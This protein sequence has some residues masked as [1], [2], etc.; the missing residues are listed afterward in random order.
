[1]TKRTLKVFLI[2]LM[3]TGCN[4]EINVN[5]QSSKQNTTNSQNESVSSSNSSV[6]VSSNSDVV[7]SS[8]NEVKNELQLLSFKAI[9]ETVAVPM[10]LEGEVNSGQEVLLDEW[11]RNFKVEAIVKNDSRLSFVDMVLYISFLDTYVV[12]TDGNG[13]YSCSTTTILEN[14]IWVTKISFDIN[15]DFSNS[16]FGY[17]EVQEINFLDLNS[18]ISKAN[19]TK[20][21]SKRVNYHRHYG[22]EF[23]RIEPTCSEEGY[24]EF[25]CEYCHETY[26][27]NYVGIDEN[28]HLFIDGICQYCDYKD[29]N[30]YVP[31]AP[32]GYVDVDINYHYVA[33]ELDSSIVTKDTYNCAFTT[34]PTT[35]DYL[36]TNKTYN[37]QYIANFVD[38][39]LEHTPEGD[40]TRGLAYAIFYSEDY[41]K[42]RVELRTG[43]SWVTN[44]MNEYAEVTAYDFKTGLQHLLDAKG[45]A[46]ELAYYIKG[47]KAY[48]DGTDPN[49]ENVGIN[50]ISDYEFEYIF[51]NP[52]PFFHTLLTSSSFKPLNRDFFE[53]MGGMLGERWDPKDCGFGTT[54][55]PQSL[56]YCGPYVLKKHTK[57]ASLSMVKNEKYW[58]KDNV[59]INEI[60]YVYNSGVDAAS[61]VEMF[62][63]GE[64]DSLD[65]NNTNY[66]LVESEFGKEYIHER[67]TGA[68]TYYFNWNLNRQTYSFGDCVSGKTTDAQKENTRK[69]ILNE[70]FRKAIFSAIP[71][72][73]LN[74]LATDSD[75]A[76]NNIRNTYTTPEFVSIGASV[77]NKTGVTHAAG[78]QYY[79]MVNREMK[80]I[81]DKNE[82]D[83]GKYRSTYRKSSESSSEKVEANLSTFKD[84][85]NSYFNKATA[86]DLAKKA[87]T[88]LEKEGVTFP[89]HIDYLCYN[90]DSSLL[91]QAQLLRRIVEKTLNND[92]EFIEINIQGT[93]SMSNYE[94]SH[95]LAP[96]GAD[97]NF[98][99]SSGTG[100]GPEYGDP[101]T[102]LNTL[103]WEGELFNN[104]GFD[105]KPEDKVI[106]EQVLGDYQA[107]Y[108]DAQENVSDVDVRY[109]KFAAAEA[110]LLSSAVIMPN[111][112][113]GGGYAISRIVSETK[114][115]AKYGF[116]I[117]RYKFMV[118]SSTPL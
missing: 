77:E 95:F 20:I 37:Q 114:Q 70:N 89:V 50:I 36:A 30:A 60:N 3:L 49:F 7:N 6:I 99:L 78:S 86:L 118:V 74:A 97:M 56:L 53:E 92:C 14:E 54:T 91:A 42:L 85:E 10:T 12:F 9:D 61:L 65:V 39:L 108:E 1:M 107:L 75:L 48:A 34:D 79:E 5:N 104:L 11:D 16:H 32:E 80:A 112:T 66:D 113:D 4:I 15:V 59:N 71:K 38:G 24:D 40:L 28:N 55:K 43:V 117:Y 52:T 87:K 101:A 96:T 82:D 19:L 68:T 62:K 13:D 17:I 33:D 31:K 27:D 57:G 110:E 102:F 100:W 44:N 109:A 18:S 88:E 72:I 64:L 105:R 29:Y 93:S 46:K 25:T 106:Y 21:D 81:N 47:A 51:E 58:D 116:D 22:E 73:E 35:F 94:T 76:I 41:S 84:R 67:D 8:N 83:Y 98:D 90:A 26:R 23:I 2:T 115:K 111:T 63:N 45:D 69:A 103:A